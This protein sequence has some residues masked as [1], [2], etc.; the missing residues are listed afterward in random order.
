MAGGVFVAFNLLY[1]MGC[2]PSVEL[3]EVSWERSEPFDKAASFFT[4]YFEGL[5][6]FFGTELR[7]K[8]SKYLHT[9]AKDG[10][11]IRCTAGRTGS[12]TWRVPQT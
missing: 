10:C 3:Q 2:L 5:N 11:V 9:V 4:D 6:N 1:A 12:V 7:R 8:I